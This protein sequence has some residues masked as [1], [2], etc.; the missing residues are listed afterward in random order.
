MDTAVLRTL[1]YTKI[2]AML[3]DCTG[4]VMGRELAEALT[5]VAVLADVRMRLHETRE[6]VEILAAASNIPLGGARDVRALLQRAAIGAMLT[7]EELTAVGSSL[8]AARRMKAFFADIDME[9]AQLKAL[10]QQITVLRNVEDVIERTVSEHGGVR[11]EASSELAHIRREIRTAQG[12]IKEKLDSI[13]RSQEYQKYFQDALVTMRG[14]RYVIP[15]KQEYRHYFPGIV[16]D[17]SASGATVF[18]E[19]MV[20]VQLNNDIKQ[21]MAAEKNEVERIL[22]V[23]SGQIARYSEEIRQNGEILAQLDFAFAKAKLAQ[24]M[25]AVEAVVNE[26]GIVRLKKARH[27]LI[28]D[29][30]VVPIDVWLGDTFDTLLITGPNTGGKTVTLKTVGLLALM[31]QAGLYIPAE[32]DSEMAVFHNI[33]A[34]I[35]DEQSIEQSLSTFSAHMTHIV[36]ILEKVSADDLVLFD[37]LGAGTDPD[38]RGRPCDGHF[39][40][41]ISRRSKNDSYNAL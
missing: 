31:T 11:D 2:R 16:H 24:Q 25:K 38:E 4:S 34:D 14:D 10:T 19:P 39:G 1:E 5:P 15:I 26:Q 41:S 35:G 6:A 22:R 23:V 40:N 7:P 8:Y 18:I 27:P 9:A 13:L 28:P 20:V 37:E 29:D 12:R 32:P 36:R 33:F 30:M 3:A 17:Q 21:H